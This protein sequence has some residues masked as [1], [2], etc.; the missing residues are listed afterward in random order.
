MINTTTLISIT[1]AA[2]VG[3]ILI[4]LVAMLV[5]VDRN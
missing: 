4:F 1:S 2:L 3:S 5:R